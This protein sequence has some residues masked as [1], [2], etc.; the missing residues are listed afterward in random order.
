MH[1]EVAIYRER[2]CGDLKGGGCPRVRQFEGLFLSVS[3]VGI[4]FRMFLVESF[5]IARF[6][7]DMLTGWRS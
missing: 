5:V 3:V 6:G 1:E 4:G 7:F 2:D